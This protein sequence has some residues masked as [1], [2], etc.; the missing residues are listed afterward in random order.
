MLHF[1]PEAAES[2]NKGGHKLRIEFKSK[3]AIESLEK[4]F[5]QCPASRSDFENPH[6]LIRQR[7]R[8]FLGNR[9]INQEALAEPTAFRST[10]PAHP[11]F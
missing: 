4:R 1:E 11:E 10:H 2:L 6:R 9:S 3:H 5:G 8:D 7:R